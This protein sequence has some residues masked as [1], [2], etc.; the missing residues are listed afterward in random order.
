MP[1]SIIVAVILAFNGTPTS[2]DGKD[3][4]VTLQGD[5][6]QVSR[7][8]AAGMIAI[9]QM[10]TNGGGWFGA[11]SAHPFENPNYFT[12]AVES[13]SIFLISVAFVF[14]LGILYQ[15]E[16]TIL[17]HIWGDDFFLRHFYIINIYYETKG[18]L[19]L[20]EWELP[21][22]SVVWKARK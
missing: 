8:P 18:I 3:S 10:G 14:A 19:Q 12:N 9:K 2:Y 6:V 11:N 21:D 7:G 4:I 13:I 15:Q 17:D 5:S 1:L 20:I 22:I 16:K